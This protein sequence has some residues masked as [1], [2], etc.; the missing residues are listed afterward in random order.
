MVFLVG[1][2]SISIICKL[3]DLVLDLPCSGKISSFAICIIEGGHLACLYFV[4]VCRDICLVPET[5]R[6][7]GAELCYQPALGTISRLCLDITHDASSGNA[8]TSFVSVLHL[9]R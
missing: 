8:A 4:T 1:V 7:R 5:T 3:L 6:G 2:L 9:K